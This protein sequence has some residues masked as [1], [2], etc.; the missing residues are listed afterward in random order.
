MSRLILLALFVIAAAS[1]DVARA[2]GRDI[3]KC[4]FAVKARCASGDV[5]VALVDGAVQSV[6]V[7][8]DWCALG[9][10]PAYS[11]TINSSRSDR[12]SKW[13]QEGDETIIAN[14]APFNAS[15]PDL[16]KVT[17]GKNVSIDLGQAQSLGRCGAGAELPQAIVIPDQ[18]AACRVWLGDR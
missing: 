12:D 6:E 17:V 14:L 5:R 13:S 7:N 15:Q 3:R 1:T 16:V 11:C 10:G 18:N 9:G 4:A 2:G 8:V